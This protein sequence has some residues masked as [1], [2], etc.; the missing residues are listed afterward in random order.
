V[1][2]AVKHLTDIVKKQ[3]HNYLTINPEWI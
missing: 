1:A 2:S 3:Y